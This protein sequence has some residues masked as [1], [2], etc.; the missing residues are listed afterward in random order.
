MK[1]ITPKTDMLESV[2]VDRGSYSALLAEGVDNSK[3]AG[4]TRIIL[5]LDPDLIQIQDNG[6]GITRDRELALFTLGD[7]AAMPTTKLGRYGIGIKYHII[8]AGN[9][10]EVRSVSID[11]EMKHTQNWQHMI[12]LKRWEIEDPKWKPPNGHKHGTDIKIRNLRWKPRPGPKDVKTAREEL[13]LM[14][15]PAL[16]AGLKI[17]LNGESLLALREPEMTDIVEDDIWISD[18]KGAHVRGG[19][20][21]KTTLLCGIDLIYEHRVIMSNSTFGS[22]SYMG[23]SH[24]FARVDLIGPWQLRRFKDGLAD[25]DEPELRQKVE[26]ILRPVLEKCFTHQME[27]KIDEIT[28]LVDE[29]LAGAFKSA[30]RRREEKKDNPPEPDRNPVQKQKRKSRE[31]QTIIDGIESPEAI[32]LKPQSRA[33]LKISFEPIFEKYGYGQFKPGEPGDADRIIIAVDNPHI[34]AL[35]KKHN[36]KEAARTIFIIACAIYQQAQAGR[37]EPF[38]LRLWQMMSFQNDSLDE[39]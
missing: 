26:A 27:I 38:G 11:G 8:A 22:G 1:D 25:N 39:S 36:K 2:R 29:M 7:H 24:M 37:D 28:D 15:Y 12:D 17:D 33:K 9:T 16:D 34:I 4:A 20:I 6:I 23:T 21:Q 10:I 13:A 3:D 31:P 18:G 35:L 30:K 19:L 32:D 14:F 5:K